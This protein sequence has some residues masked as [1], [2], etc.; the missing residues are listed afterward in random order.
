MLAPR[1][2][3]ATAIDSGLPHAVATSIALAEEPEEAA[4]EVS[5]MAG[6]HEDRKRRER[7]ALERLRVADRTIGVVPAQLLVR[8]KSAG[9]GVPGTL[10]FV[11][12]IMVLFDSES[13]AAHAT[14][15]LD[16]L[17]GREECKRSIRVAHFVTEAAP[18]DC[19]PI[20]DGW[21]SR[22]HRMAVV[23]RRRFRFSGAEEHALAASAK[24]EKDRMGEDERRGSV[25]ATGFDHAAA[26]AAATSAA[27]AARG[28]GSV[29]S[30]D[31]LYAASL[32]GGGGGGGVLATSG[33]A[34][35]E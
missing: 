11:P 12:R 13:P 28:A 16:A 31:A 18:V 19:A 24:K 33:G 8:H 14:R 27:A 25:V 21:L 26:A 23:Y 9:H 2:A 20:E 35:S 7:L 32:V 6:E 17:T 29:E 5:R 1:A 10:K 34:A 30:Q 15:M 4:D 3:V 22:I